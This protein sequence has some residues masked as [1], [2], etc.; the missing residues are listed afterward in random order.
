MLSFNLSLIIPLDDHLMFLLIRPCL[1]FP[2]RPDRLLEVTRRQ[3]SSK[4]Q[5]SFCL[6]LAFLLTENYLSA[7]YKY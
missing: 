4:S 7:D 3:D 1:P 2:C 6:S 5:V